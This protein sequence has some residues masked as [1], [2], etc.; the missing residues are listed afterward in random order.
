MNYRKLMIVILKEGTASHTSQK[1]AKPTMLVLKRNG[2]FGLE[3]EETCQQRNYE[4][5][6]K[7][8]TLR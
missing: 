4:E 1:V 5:H 6:I 3:R 8:G 7:K 2:F